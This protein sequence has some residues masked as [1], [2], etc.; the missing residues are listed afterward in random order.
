MAVDETF[1]YKSV[2][3][4][5]ESHKLD[6][7]DKEGYDKALHVLDRAL[8]I[9]HVET[10]RRKNKSDKLA[11]VEAMLTYERA[12]M[13]RE[14]VLAGRLASDQDTLMRRRMMSKRSFRLNSMHPMLFKKLSEVCN[15]IL[16]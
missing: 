15:V 12:E 10:R 5:A 2:H 14:G 4:L 6:A 16:F 9:V 7:N 1:W 8:E 13:T 11:Y 3:A